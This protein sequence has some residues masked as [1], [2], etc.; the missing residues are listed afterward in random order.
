ML[1]PLKIKATAVGAGRSRRLDTCFLRNYHF[2]FQFTKT[3][4]GA[5]EGANMAKYGQLVSLSP[6]DFIDCSSYT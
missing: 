5:L 6:Q 1:R 3:Q 2:T 4:A